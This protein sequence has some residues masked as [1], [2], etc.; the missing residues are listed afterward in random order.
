M[1]EDLIIKK[2]T[3]NFFQI[4]I[5]NNDKFENL[6]FNIKDCNLPFGLEQYNNKYLI[7]IEVD[8]VEFINLVRLLEKNLISL[9]N[10]EINDTFELKSVFHK[11]QNY[12]LLCKCHIKMNKNTIISKYIN[13]NQELSIF[14]IEKNEKYNIQLE[15]SGIWIYKNTYGLYININ[16]ILLM[17]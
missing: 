2:T 9:L 14:K 5:K 4:N 15:I 17:I 13:N 16:S 7:N 8:N 10:N 11:K 6:K 12:K 3:K 1:I